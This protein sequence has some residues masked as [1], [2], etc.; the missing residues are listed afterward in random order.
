MQI[1][2]APSLL[3]VAVLA[4]QAIH[5]IASHEDTTNTPSDGELPQQLQ[6]SADDSG[7]A[8]AL[9]SAAQANASTNATSTIVLR[10]RHTSLHS[11][12]GTP[13]NALLTVRR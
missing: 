9:A 12:R 4:R 13:L 3:T 8:A 5:V 10:V 6:L 7:M 2:G 1:G 11:C